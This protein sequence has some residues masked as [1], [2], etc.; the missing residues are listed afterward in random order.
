MRVIEL[1]TDM[2][3]NVNTVSGMT[4]NTPP[5][6]CGAD[7]TIVGFS[8]RREFVPLMAAQE[9]ISPRI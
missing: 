3:K 2:V 5:S 7:N 6:C 8:T 9:K 1:T 4:K